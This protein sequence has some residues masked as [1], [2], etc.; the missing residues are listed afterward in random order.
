MT[1][2]QIAR[3][4]WRVVTKIETDQ[5]LSVMNDDWSVDSE[6]ECD[7]AKCLFDTLDSGSCDTKMRGVKFFMD[8]VGRVDKFIEDDDFTEAELRRME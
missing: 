5:Q 4:V 1:A 3:I 8:L 7:Y 6:N 2:L